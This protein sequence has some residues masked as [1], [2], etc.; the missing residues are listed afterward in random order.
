MNDCLIES[1]KVSIIV[2]IYNSNKNGRLQRLLNCL[3]AQTLSAI[4]II[5]ILDCPT[6]GSDLVVK[7]EVQGDN[8]FV[9][10]ENEE[11]LHI[12]GSR[13]RGLD[14]A[15]GEFVAFVDHDDVLDA[16]MY[17]DLYEL[18]VQDRADVVVSPATIQIGNNKNVELFDDVSEKQSDFLDYLVGET[19]DKERESS[20]YPY[21]YGN[22]NMWNKIF[23]LALIRETGLRFVDTRRCCREDVLFQMHFF[24]QTRNIAVTSRSYYTHILYA[25]NTNYSSSVAYNS[26]LS[27]CN[28]LKEYMDL[29]LLY[30]PLIA[31]E[32]V[33]FT[34]TKFLMPVFF[35]TGL[36][37]GAL[38]K[39]LGGM[40][41]MRLLETLS[42]QA[43]LRL[44]API[45]TKLYYAS[46]TLL[47]KAL[48]LMRFV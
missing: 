1:V 48:L 44:H 30:S 12:G 17:A 27:M 26:D 43:S 11:N 33:T 41:R 36:D 15:R 19:S 21:L 16:W 4:E 28:F 45:K 25:D 35:R 8:R 13:N 31:K 29:F 5:L 3:K 7:N 37:L 2:P 9:V 14:I 24:C 23:R 22:G 10:L 6:D 34:L 47:F 20:K 38:K 32:R 46:H 42:V 39:L 18:A 40:D